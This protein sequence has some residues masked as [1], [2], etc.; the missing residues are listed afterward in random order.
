[1]FRKTIFLFNVLSAI[2][3]L[4]AYLSYFV[5]PSTTVIPVYFGLSFPF[6][7]ILNILF[8]VFWMFKKKLQLFLSLTLLL[9]GI[10]HITN[11][12][13]FHQPDPSHTELKV[14]SYNVHLFDVYEFRRDSESC[15]HLKIYDFIQ[16]QSAD[17]LCFQEFYSEDTEEMNVMQDMLHIQEATNYHIDYFQTLRKNHHWGIAT[18]S[19]YPV[20][21]RQRYQ[22]RNSIGN[23]CI[24]TD[25][26]YHTD[27]I[28]IFNVH[29]ESWHFQQDDYAFLKDM[30]QTFSENEVVTRSL[31]NIHW[32]VEVAYKKRSQQIEQLKDLIEASPFPTL[33]CGD[34]NDLPLSYTYNQMNDILSDAFLTKGNGFG[35]T[36]RDALP[37]FRIDYIFHDDHFETTEFHTFD[38]P[39]SDHYPITAGFRLK[40][41]LNE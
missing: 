19:K 37:Y 39:Y 27:T 25:I 29:L 3:L 11:I 26:I 4:L 32:K 35:K 10:P 14:L 9:A 38:L 1:M 5:K 31:K 33:V 8:V 2:G 20:I 17:I 12:I 24:Y 21:N 7:Y 28:R 34:F 40:K 13:Q 16:E 30:H 23:Y 6:W 36:F 22:F 15:N 18:F 41:E